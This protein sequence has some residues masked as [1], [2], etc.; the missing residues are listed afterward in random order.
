MSLFT[1]RNSPTASQ[2]AIR[3]SFC[4]QFGIGI[5][6]STLAFRLAVAY[7]QLNVEDTAV[8]KGCGINLNS[9]VILIAA[10]GR[11][12]S[13]RYL[14]P[15]AQ[16]DWELQGFALKRFHRTPEQCQIR[17]CLVA[18]NKCHLRLMHEHLCLR[19]QSQNINRISVMF[20]EF[21]GD[22]TGTFPFRAIYQFRQLTK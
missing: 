18:P 12:K 16:T 21:L 5:K 11:A 2:R 6:Q 7:L 15:F 9:S 1:G 13:A 22:A 4:R 20:L 17:G 10:A 8:F 3:C 14:Q 19:S